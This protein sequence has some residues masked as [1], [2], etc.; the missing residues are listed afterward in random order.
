MGRYSFSLVFL[1]LFL[2][3]KFTDAGQLKG[4]FKRSCR[5]S[6][7]GCGRRCC[8][9]CGLSICPIPVNMISQKPLREILCILHQ[10]S[11]GLTVITVRYSWPRF[12]ATAFGHMYVCHNCDRNASKCLMGWSKWEGRVSF[13]TPLFN[14]WAEGEI[15]IHL[16]VSRVLTTWGTPPL[17]MPSSS[18]FT[19]FDCF[20]QLGSLL[21]HS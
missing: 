17:R 4:S 19:T 21:D 13:L 2:L 6:C 18:E 11:L 10:C 12:T 16:S 7:D 20:W 1:Q 8:V 14:S 15:V 3:V 5:H 9:S